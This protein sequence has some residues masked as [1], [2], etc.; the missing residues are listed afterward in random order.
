MKA[1]EEKESLKRA[2][3]HHKHRAVHSQHTAERLEHQLQET[4]SQSHQSEH[5]YINYIIITFNITH[6]ILLVVYTFVNYVIYVDVHVV[7]FREVR[8][9]IVHCVIHNCICVCVCCVSCQNCELEEVRSK[10][11]QVASEKMRQQTELSSLST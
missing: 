1:Q 10:L 3:R 9:N 11:A 6:I 8:G 2:A 7:Q 5:N 4:V